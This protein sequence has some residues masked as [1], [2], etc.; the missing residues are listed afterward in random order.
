MALTRLIALLASTGTILPQ[1][2][3]ERGKIEDNNEAK[4]RW[5]AMAFEI[6]RDVSHIFSNTAVLI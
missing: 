3:L 2:L 5:S 1:L 6:Y 4:A